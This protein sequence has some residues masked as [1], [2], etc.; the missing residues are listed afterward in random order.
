MSDVPALP[1]YGYTPDPAVL[2]SLA[3]TVLLLALAAVK[4]VVEAWLQAT[5][6][7]VPFQWIPIVYTTAIS[8]GI[9]VA[10]YLG[11]YRPIGAAQSAQAVLVRDK[12]LSSPAGE[13]RGG[14]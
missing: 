5:T 7:D 1:G 6:T 9:A 2:L 14:E 8:F 11:L 3:I 13:A 10:V 12:A 4:T